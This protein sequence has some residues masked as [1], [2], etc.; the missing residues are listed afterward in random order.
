MSMLFG[1]DVYLGAVSIL[2]S[3]EA[4]PKRSLGGGGS[5][6]LN[7]QDLVGACGLDLFLCLASSGFAWFADVE[8]AVTATVG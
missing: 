5:T 1:N 2:E 7:L 6:A 8:T 3:L 4:G